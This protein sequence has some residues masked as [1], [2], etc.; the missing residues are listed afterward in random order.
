MTKLSPRLNSILSNIALISAIYAAVFFD[1]AII[2]W[3]VV[4]FIWVMLG[5]YLTVLLGV[6]KNQ[7]QTILRN[8]YQLNAYAAWLMD[9]ASFAAFI[10]VGWYFTAGAY[11]ASCI[12]LEAIYALR[13]PKS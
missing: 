11:A 6:D 1:I 8:G 10:Y 4:G 2:K 9:I 12:V 3:I 13:I 7:I 5:L